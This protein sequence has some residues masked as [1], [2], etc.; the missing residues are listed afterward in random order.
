MDDQV[1]DFGCDFRLQLV[2]QLLVTTPEKRRP[3][4]ASL[5]CDCRGEV[6]ERMELRPLS[7]IAEPF[8]L[9]DREHQ[10]ARLATRFPASTFGSVEPFFGPVD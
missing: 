5:D 2:G 10:R 7:L 8:D 9:S 3:E 6:L 4:L 1:G